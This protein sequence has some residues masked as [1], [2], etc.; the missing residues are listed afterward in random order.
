M[1]T[2]AVSS[3]ISLLM[4]G[5]VGCSSSNS[6]GCNACPQFDAPITADEC[7]AAAK[8]A[9]CASG[10]LLQ[11]SGAGGAGSHAC[12]QGVAYQSCN[13]TDCHGTVNACQ[14]TAP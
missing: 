13:W 1:V 3:A 6:G 7:Q 14:S 9:G 10:V 5:A 4:V 12:G 2:A 8:A 11:L